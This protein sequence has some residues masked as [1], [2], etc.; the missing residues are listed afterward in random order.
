MERNFSVMDRR[1]FA[2]QIGSIFLILFLG[3]STGARAKTW[4]VDPQSTIKFALKLAAAGDTIRIMPGT[5]REGNI[6]VKK[7]VTIIGVAF[8][9][10][11][12][13]NKYEIFTISAD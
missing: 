13:E 1:N 9:V 8:P 3:L 6:V 2:V 12:G 5:Y 7:S 11:D 4:V 10:L